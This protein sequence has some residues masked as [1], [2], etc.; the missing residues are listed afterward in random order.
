MKL[1]ALALFS[2]LVFNYA[3]AQADKENVK[4]RTK[5]YIVNGSYVS[6]E[7][8]REAAKKYPE[9][10]RLL[11]AGPT[12]EQKV[13]AIKCDLSDDEKTVYCD[14]GHDYKRLRSDINDIER[15]V[16]KDDDHTKPSKDATKPGASKQ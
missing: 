8:V 7:Y 4:E 11:D 16:V 2:I 5:W 6:E 12:S 9:Y 14:N 3:Y 10:R 13:K 15:S 1:Q